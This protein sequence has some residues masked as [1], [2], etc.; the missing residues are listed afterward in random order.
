MY[1]SIVVSSK[2][3]SLYIFCY[4]YEMVY[5][6]G[7]VICFCD[8]N[9]GV[10]IYIQRMCESTFIIVVSS[11]WV[12]LYIFCYPYEVLYIGGDVI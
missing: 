4:P 2:W 6:G 12:S 10:S 11:K 7:D 5:I 8:V 9:M 3:V 1:F